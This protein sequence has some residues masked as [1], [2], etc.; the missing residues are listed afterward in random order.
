MGLFDSLF[1]SSQEE[2][3]VGVP[4]TTNVNRLTKGQKG[5]LGS[6]NAQLQS[7][8]AGGGRPEAFGGQLSADTSPLLQQ[9]FGNVGTLQG[10]AGPF[11]RGLE[12]LQGQLADFDPQSV[13]DFFNANVLEPSNI[14]YQDD[15]R[16]IRE[17][18]AGTGNSGA[19]NRA[20]ADRAVRKNVGNNA[21]LANLLFQGEQAQLGRQG[22]ALNAALGLPLE[23]GRAVGAQ[24]QGLEQQGLDRML[25]EFIR[26][27]GSV[28]PLLGLSNVALGTEAFTPVTQFP[29][30]QFGPSGLSQISS[31]LGNAGNAALGSAAIKKGFF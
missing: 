10:D 20:L 16:G 2:S 23:A 17:G 21:T 14:R 29:N 1:G 27:T 25:Q 11:G 8:L 13:M 7:V 12:A 19:L 30:Q 31:L 28:D 15:I 9:L 4:V 26:T 3:P 6:L 22:N 24:Q 18:F 5:T